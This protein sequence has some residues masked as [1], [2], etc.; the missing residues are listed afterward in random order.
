MARGFIWK[1]TPLRL[2]LTCLVAI[3]YSGQAEE[4]RITTYNAGLLTST[5]FNLVPCV[6]ERTV[7]QAE[8]MLN[9]PLSADPKTHFAILLQEVWTQYGFDTYASIARSK[10]Y[11]IYPDTY[12]DVA[13]NGEIIIT[14]M[15]VLKKDFLPFPDDDHAYRGIRSIVVQ[16]DKG[17]VVISNAHTSYS[18]SSGF[19]PQHREQF[20]VNARFLDSVLKTNYPL[21][22]AGDFNAGPNMAYRQATYDPV[23]TIWEDGILPVFKTRHMRPVG[24]ETKNTWSEETNSLV[25]YPARLIR[26]LNWYEYGMS[27]WDQNS[28]RIDHIMAPETMKVIETGRSMLRG[29]PLGWTCMGRA[30]ENGRTPLSDHYAVYAKFMI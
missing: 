20:A 16:S 27:E 3:G 5:G 23:K 28:A 19:L 24:D 18:D 7:P 12:S 13:Y 8:H 2:V 29:E 22:F 17:P 4:I 11:T 14:N 25:S 10:G 6:T 9:S 26:W 21:I 30:D 15:K 1:I